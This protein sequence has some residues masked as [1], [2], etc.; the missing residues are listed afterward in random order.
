[1][2]NIFGKK[3]TVAEILKENKRLISRG[4]RELDRE[5]LNMEREEKK[6]ITDIKKNA[7]DQQMVRSSFVQCSLSITETHAMCFLLSFSL[8]ALQHLQDVVKI[9]AKDLVRTRNYIKKFIVMRSR[10]QAVNLKLTVRAFFAELMLCFWGLVLPPPPL[11]L[12]K[13]D[14]I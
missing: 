9:Q 4:I 8:F 12:L 13:S 11:A 3:K 7:K 14:K 5:R 6:L 1:M 2:G 10:L